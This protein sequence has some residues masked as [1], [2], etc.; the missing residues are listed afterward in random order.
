MSDELKVFQYTFNESNAT[1]PKKRLANI[2]ITYRK[3]MMKKKPHNMPMTEYSRLVS[4]WWKELSEPKKSELQRRYHIDR[5]RKQYLPATKDDP[6]SKRL[7][8]LK[9]EPSKEFFNNIE[10]ILNK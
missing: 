8:K 6:I 4:K 7:G 1:T 2:F 10:D 5:D 9:E 3:E